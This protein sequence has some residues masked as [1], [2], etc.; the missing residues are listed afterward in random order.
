MTKSEFNAAKASILPLAKAE[1]AK[2][3]PTRTELRQT[4][5]NWALWLGMT[6]EE[7]EDLIAFLESE[8]VTV[9]KAFPIS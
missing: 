4:A 3:H 6:E 7:T 8:I 9:I 2:E 1:H 5:V